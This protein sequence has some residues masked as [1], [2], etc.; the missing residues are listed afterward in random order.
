MASSSSSRIRLW[1]VT[2]AIFA[3]AA[4]EQET[5]AE[6][7]AAVPAA[8]GAAAEAA[9]CPITGLGF[10]ERSVVAQLLSQQES[11]GA[12]VAEACL[13]EAISM[14]LPAL[15]LLVR[16]L[17]AKDAALEALPYSAALEALE[18]VGDSMW[19]HA[20]LLARLGHNDKALPR[21]EALTRANQQNAK[22]WNSY[23]VTLATHGDVPAGIV[24]LEKAVAIEANDKYTDNLFRVKLKLSELAEAQPAV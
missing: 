12:E 18:P 22:L 14:T 23:G 8:E 13:R 17:S 24:A 4:A 6:P 2:V 10:N 16:L 3:L 11:G 20:D 15:K 5:A 19:V 7:A 1:A 21:Y 9:K